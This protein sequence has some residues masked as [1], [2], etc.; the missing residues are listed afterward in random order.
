MLVTFSYIHRVALHLDTLKKLTPTVEGA[1]HRDTKLDTVQRVKDL[2]I[3][4]LSSKWNVFNNSLPSSI[5]ESYGRGGIKDVKA[6]RDGENRGNK[7]FY[8]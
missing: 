4:I 2:V 7:A 3:L 5:M 8:T 6:R 1:K